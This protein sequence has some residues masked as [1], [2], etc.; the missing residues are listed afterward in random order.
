VLLRLSGKLYSKLFYL[1]NVLCHQNLIIFFAA[2]SQYEFLLLQEQGPS[3]TI[4]QHTLY[5]FQ[6]FQ[7]KAPIF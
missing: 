1:K 6:Y 5:A 2:L 3:K 7:C 4:E